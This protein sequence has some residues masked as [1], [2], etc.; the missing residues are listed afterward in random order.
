[1]IPKVAC[2]TF[3]K[4]MA[5]SLTNSSVDLKRI[6]F[7]SFI[8]SLGMNFL[9][10][11]SKS[12]IELRL[13]TY[14][15]F[16]VVRHPFD[17]LL[18]AYADKFA[19]P[20][21]NMMMVT[22]LRRR[23]ESRFG[24]FTCF[25]QNGQPRLSLNQFLELVSDDKKFYDKH[26]QSYYTLCQPCLIDYDHIIRLETADNDIGIVLDHLNYTGSEERLAVSNR[27]ENMKRNTKNKL[28][29]VTRQMNLM[30]SDIL[31]G[32]LKVFRY[33]FELFGYSWNNVS[34]AAFPS[35]YCR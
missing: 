2:M 12:D 17:R 4:I 21:N 6:N 32:L 24:N 9:H 30:E 13:D 23:A 8:N 22:R 11:Y 28:D 3:Q 25:D 1:M 29:V 16:I 15:K 35:K 31:H 18:S 34:G 33:D 14:F 5:R 26:W 20:N 7:P 19:D 27:H 10:K